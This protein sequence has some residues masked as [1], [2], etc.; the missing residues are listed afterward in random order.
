MY[1]FNVVLLQTSYRSQYTSL[2]IGHGFDGELEHVT[3]NKRRQYNHKCVKCQVCALRS[4][5]ICWRWNDLWKLVKPTL[6]TILTS[7]DASCVRGDQNIHMWQR[8]AASV[9]S[10]GLQMFRTWKWVSVQPRFDKQVSAWIR[11][12]NPTPS[13]EPAQTAVDETSSSCR[14]LVSE[15][16]TFPGQCRDLRGTDRG[17]TRFS[18]TASKS[19]HHQSAVLKLRRVPWQTLQCSHL[20]SSLFFLNTSSSFCWRHADSKLP[21]TNRKLS[22]CACACFWRTHEDITSPLRSFNCG[23]GNRTSKTKLKKEEKE[24]ESTLLLAKVK[25]KKE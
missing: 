21:I 2:S 3:L 7:W 16:R 13:A 17:A 1:H 6:T 18:S 19:A 24:A 11:S 9:A 23:S 22:L 12:I 20:A 5:R 10:S 4:R 8:G 25:K 14:V 15:I